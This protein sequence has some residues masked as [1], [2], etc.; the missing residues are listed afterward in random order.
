M[1]YCVLLGLVVGTAQGQNTNPWQADGE[2]PADPASSLWDIVESGVGAPVTEEAAE[3]SIEHADMRFSEQGMLKSKEVPGAP[4]ATLYVDPIAAVEKPEEESDAIDFS[5]FDIPVMI[6]D[7]VERW[8]NYFQGRGRKYFKRWLSRETKYRAMIERNLEARDLPMDLI[9]LSMIESGFSPHATSTASAVGLWQFIEPTARAYG[10]RVDYWVDERRDPEIATRAAAKML[11]DLQAMFGDWYLSWAAYNTGS[12]R[13]R[14][15]IRKHGSS[16]YWELVRLKALSSE[17]RNYVPKLLAAA[18]IGKNPEQYGFT[19][20][21]PKR[22]LRYSTVEVE[23][24]VTLDVIAECAGVD[25]SAIVALNPALLRGATPPRSTTRVH[26]PLGTRSRF[27]EA[28]GKLSES[29]RVSYRRHRVTTGESLGSIAGLYG[30]PTQALIEFN[31]IAEPDR[32][33]VG[34][35]LVVPIPG[36]AE[37]VVPASPTRNDG[38]AQS[39]VLVTIQKGQTLGSI[40]RIHGV[41]VSELVAWNK[42]ENADQ[43]LVGQKIR[44]YSAATQASGRQE[45]TVVPGDSLYGIAEHHGCTVDELKAWNGLRSSTIQPGQVL[46]LGVN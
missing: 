6:N 46:R 37:P 44:V 22:E 1:I 24:S 39:A 36:G 19:D 33:R 31:R 10:L 40:A 41:R 28:F 15:A 13:L 21:K 2:G 4:D 16:D 9:Y 27:Q 17:T 12:G 45:Y 25:E 35:E 34:A 26:I 23:G 3:A 18:I 8:M 14:S 29:D 5:A 42:L 7:D 43:V 11:S 32:I 30:V 38:G 20:I